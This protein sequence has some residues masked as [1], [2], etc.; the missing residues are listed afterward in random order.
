MALG[1]L[2]RM[3]SAVVHRRGSDVCLKQYWRISLTELRCGNILKIP[4]E[5]VQGIIEKIIKPKY[6]HI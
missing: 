4:A 6:R 1:A 5:E 3:E 2:A